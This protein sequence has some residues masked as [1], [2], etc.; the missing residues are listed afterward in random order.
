M[1]DMFRIFVIMIFSVAFMFRL[2]MAFSVD[3]SV[4]IFHVVIVVF[5]GFIQDHREIAGVQP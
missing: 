3:M 2:L 1:T 4:E 5:V